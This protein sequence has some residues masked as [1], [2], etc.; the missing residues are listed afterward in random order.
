MTIDG[1]CL[2][3]KFAASGCDGNTWF[4]KLIDSGS[5]AESHPCQRTLRLSL[6]NK[7]NCMAV[8]SKE[9]SF[10]IKDLRIIG[11]NKVILNIG[12]RSILYEY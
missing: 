3:I 2:N 10:D 12:D 6:E 5:I 7:E 1:D 9:I 4:V 8:I 11:N